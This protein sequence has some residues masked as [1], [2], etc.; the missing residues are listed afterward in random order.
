M[1]HQ[2]TSQGR[3]AFIFRQIEIQMF[4]SVADCKHAIQEERRFVG[5]N[6]VS[7]FLILFIAY[8]AHDF[9]KQIFQCE[10]SFHATMLVDDKQEMGS[11]PLNQF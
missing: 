2:K 1:G 10:D 4:V 11:R 6:L 5:N 9:L 7:D 3:K 8:F